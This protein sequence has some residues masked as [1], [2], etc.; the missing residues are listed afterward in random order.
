MYKNKV[1]IGVA[2]PTKFTHKL[3]EEQGWMLSSLEPAD[4][5][6]VLYIG[7]CASNGDMFSCTNSEND[8]Y[9]HCGYLNG[10]VY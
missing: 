5:K 8:I 2:T 9:I 6:T 4:Y 7:T 1:I 3:T 10:G